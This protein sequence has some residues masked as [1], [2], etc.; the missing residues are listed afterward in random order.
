VVDLQSVLEAFLNM[1]LNSACFI[2]FFLVKKI[3][4]V[5]GFPASTGLS[6]FPNYW[7]LN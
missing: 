5:L 6:G 1:S 7:L 3:V 2:A 4:C